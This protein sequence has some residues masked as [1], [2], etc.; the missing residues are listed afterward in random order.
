MGLEKSSWTPRRLA[1]YLSWFLFIG[2]KHSFV[3]R[4]AAERFHT[5][6]CIVRIQ[7]TLIL[8]RRD[9][10]RT[11]GFCRTRLNATTTLSFRFIPTKGMA[12]GTRRRASITRPWYSTFCRRTC[13]MQDLELKLFSVNCSLLLSG[14]SAMYSRAALLNP[15]DVFVVVCCGCL[16]YSQAKRLTPAPANSGQLFFFSIKKKTCDQVSSSTDLR[17][18]IR[19]L[20]SVTVFTL[21]RCSLSS[22][23]FS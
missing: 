22:L 9:I 8:V 5:C 2:R 11:A 1:F 6:I 12:S 4:C 21:Q 15:V 10:F 17:T 14:G 3:C 23:G 16:H 7:N 20:K 18:Y 13:E 19:H